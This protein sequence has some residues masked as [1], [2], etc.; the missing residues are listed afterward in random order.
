[1]FCSKIFRFPLKSLHCFAQGAKV[2]H[3]NVFQCFAQRFS[4]FRSKALSA[5]PKGLKCFISTG[6]NVLSKDFLIFAQKPSL[7][8]PKP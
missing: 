6:S 8:R 1:M 2:F 4:D 7:F 3:P 5:W